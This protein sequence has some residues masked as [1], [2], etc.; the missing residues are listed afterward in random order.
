[1]NR[2]LFIR[3]LRI[4]IC[5]SVISTGTA[6]SNDYQE[7]LPEGFQWLE[8]RGNSEKSHIE[9]VGT[10]INFQDWPKTEIRRTAP[11][12]SKSLLSKPE[13]ITRQNISYEAIT[14]GGNTW[15]LCS[16]SW[17]CLEK[18]TEPLPMK[19]PPGR[20]EE[21]L[22]HVSAE[23]RND[24]NWVEKYLQR[25]L[26]RHRKSKMFNITGQLTVKLCLAPSSQA[27][28]E[29]SLYR[30]TS[31]T[32]PTEALA[33]MYASAKHPEGLGTISFLT[34]SRNK[35]AVKIIFVRD[36]ICV[37]IRA[38]GNLVDEA[39]VLAYKIDAKLINQSTLTYQQLLSNRPTVTI[40]SVADK[41]KIN[42]RRTVS[43]DAAAP[44]GQKIIRIIASVDGKNEA[45]KKGKIHLA[46][47]KG[48]VSVKVTAITNELLANT[49]ER[50]VVVSE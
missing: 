38:D 23:K 35:D 47:K 37:D 46:N 16:Q 15:A 30:M 27:A 18:N 43:Y 48:K 36:N 28:Q 33:F 44:V 14:F 21:L 29:Y 40:A 5:L 32:L 11:E 41:A 10:A 1:M 22:A 4:V 13:R 9:A 31:G 19:L 20:K 12:I 6:Y 26:E 2:N 34:E 45:A 50:E 8:I 17:D 49:S 24:P 39:L 3:Y 42:G 25:K 7:M